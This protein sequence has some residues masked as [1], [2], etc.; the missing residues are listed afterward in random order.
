MSNPGLSL[1]LPWEYP[2]FLGN[3]AVIECACC[4][5]LQSFS[6]LNQKAFSEYL[7]TN[8]SNLC[9]LL[10][11]Q[12]NL[13]SIFLSRIY[14]FIYLSIISTYLSNLS[15]TYLPISSIHPSH[16]SIYNLSPFYHISIRSIYL[17]LFIYLLIDL[18]YL[19]ICHL[20]S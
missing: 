20:A 6:F 18:S 3:S 17:Y 16:L 14:L 15:H 12:S 4:N 9:N 13:S 8:Q 1:L 2:D 11:N 19:N 10:I 5:L 7:L